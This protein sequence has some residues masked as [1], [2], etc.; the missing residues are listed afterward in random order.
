MENH[1]CQT[2][3]YVG[4]IHDLG[5]LHEQSKIHKILLIF[6]PVNARMLI[7]KKS[8]LGALLRSAY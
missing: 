6:M 7:W 3:T 8:K 5:L 1:P 4:R 2:K